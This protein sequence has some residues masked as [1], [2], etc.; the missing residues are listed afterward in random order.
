MFNIP[1][2]VLKSAN[3]SLK[4]ALKYRQEIA[5]VVAILAHGKST[6]YPKWYVEFFLKNL[7]GREL[8]QLFYETSLKTNTGFFLSCFQI[9]SQ[10]NPMM[11]Q[12]LT[13]TNL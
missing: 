2:E 9:A 13:P 6:D 12:D 11:M 5:E 1:Q 7:T 10:T 3:I 8:Y 4:E